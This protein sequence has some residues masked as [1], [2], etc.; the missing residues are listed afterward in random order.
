MTVARRFIAGS[1]T[2]WACIPEG[3]LIPPRAY[4]YLVCLRVSV[5]RQQDV[6][7][8]CVR[9]LWDYCAD[10]R[11]RLRQLGQMNVCCQNCGF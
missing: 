8:L 9:L 10:F 5:K 4:N 2:V 11:Q 1:G 7:V 3:R 6:S